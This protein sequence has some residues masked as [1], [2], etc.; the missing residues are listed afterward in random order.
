MPG[1]LDLTRSQILAH[2]RRVGALDE[3]LPPGA[4]SLRRAGWAGFPDSMPRAALVGIHARVDGTNPETWKD[5]S[6]VQVWGP[7]FSAYVVAREDAPV[8]TLGRLP[9]AGSRR[10][11]AEE[12]ADALDAFLAGRTMTYSEAG[13]AMGVDPNML[14]YATLTGRVLIRWEGAGRP[15][16]WMVPPPTMEAM[17]A[18][19]ELARRHL[20]VFGASTPQ[21]FSDWAGIKPARAEAAFE[22]LGAELISARTPVGHAWILATDEASLRRQTRAPSNAIRLLPSGDTYF[23]LQG[24]D[25][26]L[27]VE[28]AS[29]R[30]ELWTSRV[31]PG[32]LLV[33]GEIAGV[34]RRAGRDVD[35]EAWR[36]MSGT[37]RD[38]VVAEAESL[39]LPEIAGQIRVRWGGAAA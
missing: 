18:R 14:R 26:E 16:V 22:A 11:R 7:R 13:H 28:D 29:G 10:V 37:E 1:A 19:L 21:A 12:T 39:P 33:D 36:G 27:L 24:R 9:D 32:A 31:W 38:R 8:F 17:E 2:R 20:H 25:R 5:P 6:V 4:D 15:T 23:L 3:R 30:A 34:W 35:I